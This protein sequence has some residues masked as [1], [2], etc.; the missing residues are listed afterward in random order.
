MPLDCLVC[1]IALDQEAPE[2]ETAAAAED[3]LFPFPSAEAAFSPAHQAE[4]EAEVERL[5][6]ENRVLKET[7][8]SAPTQIKAPLYPYQASHFGYPWGYDKNNGWHQEIESYDADKDGCKCKID[9]Y[10][11][12]LNC[13]CGSAWG[14]ITLQDDACYGWCERCF[15]ERFF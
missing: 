1:R 6:T 12:N 11:R 9:N 8:G 13:N 2:E 3:P 10:A 14:A 4:L 15:F 7:A 5:R